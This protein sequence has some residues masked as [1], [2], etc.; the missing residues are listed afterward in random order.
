LAVSLQERDAASTLRYARQFLALRKNSGALR[1]GGL[2]F[3]DAPPPVLAFLRTYGHE[4]VLCVF[5][6]SNGNALFQSTLFSN[7]AAIPMGTAETKLA[8]TTLSLSAYA[9]FFAYV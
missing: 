7:G 1:L 8:A 4:R 3:L 9:A 6:M 5:N 2:D